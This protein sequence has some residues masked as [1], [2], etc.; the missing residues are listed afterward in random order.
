MK[1]EKMLNFHE[2]IQSWTWDEEKNVDIESTKK[3]KIKLVVQF[4]WIQLNQ[5]CQL[6][7]VIL[8]VKFVF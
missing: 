8:F 2:I 4:V 3:I 7:M 6:F 1:Y 5:K